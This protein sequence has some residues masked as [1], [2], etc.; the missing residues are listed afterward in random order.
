MRVG[1]TPVPIH[2][3]RV[4]FFDSQR[5][6]GPS[7]TEDWEERFGT[8]LS[9]LESIDLDDLGSIQSLLSNVRRSREM[10]GEVS[11]PNLRAL[12]Q[13]LLDE[14][15]EAARGAL[16]GDIEPAKAHAAAAQLYARQVRDRLG[17]Q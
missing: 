10:L 1:K 9:L 16:Y 11:D 13:R 4:G 14:A 6:S 12:L 15:W 8:L 17:I 2:E 7:W 3:G 5:E